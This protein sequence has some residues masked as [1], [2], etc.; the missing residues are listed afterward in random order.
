MIGNSTSCLQFFLFLLLLLKIPVYID[1][2]S[3]FIN[4]ITN[5]INIKFIGHTDTSSAACGS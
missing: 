1:Y 2:L 3:L 5:E 4:I